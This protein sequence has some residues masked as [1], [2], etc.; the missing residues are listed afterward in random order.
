MEGQLIWRAKCCRRPMVAGG[1]GGVYRLCGPI[2]LKGS[3]FVSV[4]LGPIFKIYYVGG[5]GGGDMGF[6]QFR[7]FNI[8]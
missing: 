8:H 7:F 3:L 1:G 4:Q 2:I 5:G 6:F